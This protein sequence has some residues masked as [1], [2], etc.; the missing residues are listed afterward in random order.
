M[1]C[2]GNVIWFLF[3]GF[4]QGIS[5]TIAG[6]LWCITI[7]G[8]PVGVQCFKFASLAFLPFGKEVQ[9]GGGTFSIL[10]NILWILFSGIPL[11]LIAALNGI[12]L[13][14]TI[15]G[16]PF[17]MQCFKIAKLSFAPFGATVCY[18]RSKTNE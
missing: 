2:L 17:G 16:I 7:I 13:C 11:A 9:Y 3:G 6:L 12:L 8:I 15:I 1:G 4:W 5:W 18:A 14:C 10:V